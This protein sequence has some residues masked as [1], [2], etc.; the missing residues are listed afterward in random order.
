MGKR[1]TNDPYA[2]LGVSSKKTGVAFRMQIHRSVVP[3]ITA[4]K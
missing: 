1:L 2:E 3:V 4:G